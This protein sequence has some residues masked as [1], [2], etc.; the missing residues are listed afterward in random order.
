MNDF[1]VWLLVRVSLF[2]QIPC[3]NVSFSNLPPCFWRSVHW[4]I[5]WSVNW[6]PCFK[7]IF[8]FLTICIGVDR[9]CFTVSSKY[10][11]ENC[12]YD[13]IR[14][15]S[16]CDFWVEI[17]VRSALGL[18]SQFCSHFTLE[19]NSRSRKS[20]LNIIV[21]KNVLFSSAPVF[22]Q[23]IFQF[24]SKNNCMGLKPYKRNCPDRSLHFR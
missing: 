19:S 20:L 10:S 15:W 6:S 8:H 14:F 3:G 17:F 1:I 23:S 22:F 7:D 4:Y 13:N 12:G 5:K 16:L 18:S 21:L 9:L 24:V 2:G 11:R